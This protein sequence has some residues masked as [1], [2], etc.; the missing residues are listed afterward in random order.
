MVF[1]KHCGKA[2]NGNDESQVHKEFQ[3]GGLPMAFIIAEHNWSKQ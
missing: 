1:H 2:C 3:P